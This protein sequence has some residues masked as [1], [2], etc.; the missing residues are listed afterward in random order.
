VDYV[1]AVSSRYAGR[2]AVYEVW[3]EV[4]LTGMFTGDVA[5]LVELSRLAYQTI[6]ANDPNAI[7]LAPNYTQYGVTEFEQFLAA[8]GDAYVD[9]YG[10]HLYS[11]INDEVMN[12]LALPTPEAHRHTVNQ[13]QAVLDSR[14]VSKE[15]WITEGAVV[16][17]DQ[18]SSTR[19]ERLGAAAR[20][21]LVPLI[22]GQENFAWYTWEGIV[23]DDIQMFE[24]S[25]R[26]ILEPGVAFASVSNWMAGA[27]VVSVDIDAGNV[28]QIVITKNGETSLILWKPDIRSNTL[29]YV[30]PSHANTVFN[31]DGSS[32]SLSSN[33]VLLGPSPIRVRLG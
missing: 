23:G 4:D 28:Y 5:D 14:G 25:T 15:I 26:E 9:G 8:G 2:I 1:D 6:K 11:A 32:Q 18:T 22:S 20:A 24:P 31:L 17:L 19:D 21:F 12:R 10:V 16:G 13:F 29:S 3:N 7:V 30:V 27:T 33:Q